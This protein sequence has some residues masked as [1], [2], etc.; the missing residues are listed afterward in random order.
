MKI[1]D[2]SS[3]IEEIAPLYYQDSYDNSGLIIGHPDDTVKKTLLCTDVTEEVLDEAIKKQ[4]NL[5]ISHH[6]PIFNAIKKLNGTNAVERIVIK[7]IQHR[8]GLYAAHTNLDNASNGV[9]RIIAEKIGL[10]NIK[11][12]S[13]M[14]KTLRKLVTFCPTS[15]SGQVRNALFEA[16]AGHI[17]NYDCCSYN[18]EGKGSF[19][20]SEKANP[21]VG[22]K[23][24]VHFEPET[25]IETIFPVHLES[26]IINALLKAHPYEEVAYDIY[27]LENKNSNYGAGVIGKLLKPVSTGYFLKELKKNLKINCIKHSALTK[28]SVSIIAVCGGAGHFL[29]EKA[30][31]AGADLFISSEF[32]HNQFVDYSKKI[33]LSDIGHYEGEQ[34]VKE[35]IKSLIIKKFPKFA[36]EFSEMGKNPVSY[37]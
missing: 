31:S 14:D 4:C 16:G 21:F 11:V 35:L 8:I 27:S 33:I 19:R 29:T 3:L 10:S 7:A 22:K 17:G 6:P 1:K 25:R 18:V 24:I 15:Q 30:I 37:L 20:A 23:N 28:K 32:K 26:K 36:V 34:Y 13:P 12:L 9:S 2:I 5:V